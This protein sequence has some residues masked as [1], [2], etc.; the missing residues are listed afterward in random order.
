MTKVISIIFL[1]M[2]V[3]LSVTACGERSSVYDVV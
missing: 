2:A 1:A 3:S